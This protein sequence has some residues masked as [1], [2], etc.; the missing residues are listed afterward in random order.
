MTYPNQSDLTS[1]R[2]RA[3]TVRLDILVD[4]VS[5]ILCRRRDPCYG[6]LKITAEQV[7]ELARA[8][9]THLTLRDL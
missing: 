5:A 4:E 8:I 7:D 3:T 9:V 6:S 2:L 1:L